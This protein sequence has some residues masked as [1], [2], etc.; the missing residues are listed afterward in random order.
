[1]VS[2][3]SRN[4]KEEWFFKFP[5]FGLKLVC[6]FDFNYNRNCFVFMEI[7]IHT[8][9]VRAYVYVNEV[10]LPLPFFKLIVYYFCAPEQKI[11][12][13]NSVINYRPR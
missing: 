6:G 2:S 11:I 13:M 3:W 1:M 10:V 5:Y 4:V 7:K 12:K 8:Y 9:L